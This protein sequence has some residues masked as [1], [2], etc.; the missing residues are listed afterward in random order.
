MTETCAL[1][2][3]K[4]FYRLAGRAAVRIEDP[5]VGPTMEPVQQLGV[6]IPSIRL[7]DR[8]QRG[9]VRFRCPQGSIGSGSEQRLQDGETTEHLP[10]YF[11]LGP[12]ASPLPLIWHGQLVGSSGTGVKQGDP[13]GPLYFAVITHSL[14]CSIRDAIERVAT[15]YFPLLPFTAICDDLPSGRVGPSTYAPCGGSGSAEDSRVGPE[16]QHREMSH[17]GPS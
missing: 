8:S 9:T 7:S 15:E 12:A 4:I 16:S 14:F 10:G 11:C 6:G 2:L 5:L 1:G 17:P 3:P 13:A